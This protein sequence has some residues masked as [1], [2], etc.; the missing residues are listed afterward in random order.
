MDAKPLP[1]RPSLEQYK[2]QA[3]DLLK[4]CHVADAEAIRRVKANHPRF[5]KLSEVELRNTKLALADAQLVIAREHGVESWP[6]FAKRIEVINSE[7]AARANP[8]AAFI[9]AAIWHG[10]L[11]AAEAILTVHPEIASTSI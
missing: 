7:A 10:T 9:E 5:N 8:V 2:K 1:S 11:E 6:K 3:K 4:S